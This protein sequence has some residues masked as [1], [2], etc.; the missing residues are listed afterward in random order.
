MRP[1]PGT[2]ALVCRSSREA[3]IQVG[4]L[5]VLPIRRGYYVY[6]GSAFGPGG[7]HA[8]V[9]RHVRRSPNRHWHVDCLWPVLRIEEIW[10]SYDPARREHDW[11]RILSHAMGGSIALRRF[12]ASDCRCEAHLVFF[13]KLPSF[14]AFRAMAYRR[15]GHAGRSG[16]RRQGLERR[17]RVLER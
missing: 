3:R 6:V 7:V 4:R 5:G 1:D 10:Y 14:A 2:Y 17:E 11:A 16:L 9:A 13:D 8:R 15:R 12:G